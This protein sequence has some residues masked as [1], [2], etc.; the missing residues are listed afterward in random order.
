MSNK[1]FKVLSGVLSVLAVSSIFSIPTFAVG[2]QKVDLRN[3]IDKR[4]ISIRSQGDRDTCVLHA[5]T[6]LEEY[7]L[8]GIYGDSYNHISIDYGIQAGN[9]VTG[10]KGDPS[11]FKKFFSGYNVYGLI[12]DSSWSY[13]PV[14]K[15]NFSK[16][17]DNF[18]NFIDLGK[19]M[20][21][22]GSRL[23]GKCI[24]DGEEDEFTD[25]LIDE[26]I[27]YLN[28]GI[29][30]A[31][32]HGEHATV[33]VGYERDTSYDGGGYFIYRNS[34]GTDAGDQGYDKYTFAEIKKNNAA[35]FVYETASAFPKIYKSSDYKGYNVA[36]AP[37]KYTLTQLENMGVNDNT[38]S[39]IAIPSGYTAYLFSDD[40]FEG[41]V[42][43]I[44]NDESN[45]KNIDCDNET[46]SI[47]I[48]SQLPKVYQKINYK[49]YGVSLAPGKYTLEQLENLGISNDDLSSIT[50][51]S[52]YTVTLYQNDNFEGE[53]KTLLGDESDF[54]NLSFNNK[55][56]SI[57][58]T[59]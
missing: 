9:R 40:N 50:V 45:L 51:P 20:L 56:S 41:T 54:R 59:R 33:F 15:Y 28:R 17:N 49:G 31:T 4:G 55:A 34:W 2:P 10:D 14:A 8:S 7:A 38:I 58:I 1:S 42:T 32:A 23:A 18:S 12:P 24:R 47:K 19:N 36:L 46:S 13:D 27:S 11:S 16:W 22:D 57:L 43:K 26:V 29:P 37:G 48:V 21:K 25:K 6:F 53:S 44:T 35:L 30:V 52:G 3:E 5:M 39:S